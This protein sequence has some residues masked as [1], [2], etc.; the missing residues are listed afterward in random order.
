ME[1]VIDLGNNNRWVSRQG[2]VEIRFETQYSLCDDSD[3]FFK[4]IFALFMWNNIRYLCIINGFW[5][6]AVEWRSVSATRLKILVGQMSPTDDSSIDFFFYICLF[7]A[8]CTGSQ[9]LEF[10]RPQGWL[11]FWVV[12]PFSQSDSVMNGPLY[13]LWGILFYTVILLCVFSEFEFADVVLFS[14]RINTESFNLSL[15][16]LWFSSPAS[17]TFNLLCLSTKVLNPVASL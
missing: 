6:P 4:E 10:V 8:L 7:S 2:Q 11:L 5:L 17:A 16:S 14:K 1:A 13:F 12:I 9:F 3:I 15:V